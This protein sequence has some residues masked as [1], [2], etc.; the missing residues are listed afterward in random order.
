MRHEISTDNQSARLKYECANA[1]GCL[2]LLV[3]KQN[4]ACTTCRQRG[5]ACAFELPLLMIRCFDAQGKAA[6][7]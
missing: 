1:G 6:R 2:R 4:E 7:L 3:V 5:Q